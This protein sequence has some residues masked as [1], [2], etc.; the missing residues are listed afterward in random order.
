MLPF[1][2]KSQPQIAH[3]QRRPLRL[4]YPKRKTSYMSH[5]NRSLSRDYSNEVGKGQRV[6]NK[7]SCMGNFMACPSFVG[8]SNINNLDNYRWPH[9]FRIENFNKLS[10]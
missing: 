9:M 2:K 6:K 7:V 8:L 3:L 5:M 1:K 4:E 10:L